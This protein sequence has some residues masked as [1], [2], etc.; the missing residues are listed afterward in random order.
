MYACANIVT[1]MICKLH[2]ET[3]F[4][5]MDTYKHTQCFSW[6]FSLLKEAVGSHIG[7]DTISGGLTPDLSYALCKHR[8]KFKEMSVNNSRLSIVSLSPTVMANTL[9][10]HVLA[11]CII[12]WEIK[13]FCRG[14]ASKH[15]PKTNI[16]LYC[17]HISSSSLLFM[18]P[19]SSD[20][21]H[22]IVAVFSRGKLL[23]RHSSN[24]LKTSCMV[25]VKDLVDWEERSSYIL[26]AATAAY[27]MRKSEHLLI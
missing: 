4:W 22:C 20:I 12:Y 10:S 18:S 23:V 25:N 14:L 27:I 24:F 6:K 26:Q 11:S 1:W 8:C 7:A 16:I 19:S 2:G 9:V 3:H 15:Q 21:F 5:Q 17:S 13:H